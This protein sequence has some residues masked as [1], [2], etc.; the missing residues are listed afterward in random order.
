M[1]FIARCKNYSVTGPM[2]VLGRPIIDLA[3]RINAEHTS[4][5]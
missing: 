3:L 1:E 2:T 4:K 5:G